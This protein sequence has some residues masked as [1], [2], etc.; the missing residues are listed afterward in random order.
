M[1]D[2]VVVFMKSGRLDEEDV[3]ELECVINVLVVKWEL[4]DNWFNVSWDW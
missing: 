4:I 3:N 1:Y 2:S